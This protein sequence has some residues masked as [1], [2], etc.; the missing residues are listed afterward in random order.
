MLKTICAILIAVFLTFQFD[1]SVF[2]LPTPL[3]NPHGVSFSD[4]IVQLL[5][6]VHPTDVMD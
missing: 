3:S 2:V 1:L 4:V 5:H 6:A